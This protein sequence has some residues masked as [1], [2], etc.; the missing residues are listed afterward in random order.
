MSTVCAFYPFVSSITGDCSNLSTGAATIDFSQCTS[1]GFVINWETP[2]VSP[3]PVTINVGTTSYTQT[4]LS[5]G[6]YSAVIYDSCG[7][8]GRTV[9]HISTGTC[10]SNTAVVDT[11][12]GLSNGQLTSQVTYCYGNGAT[13]YLYSTTKGYI[14]SAQTSGQLYTFDTLSADTYYVIGNDGGGCTGSS[15]TCIVKSSTTLSFG[16]YVV[17]TSP[18]NLPANTG[19]GKLYITGLT[20]TAP[21]TY[22]WSNGN[23]HDHITGLTAGA[24]NVTVTDANGCSATTAAIVS[25][26]QQITFGSF[27]IVQSP[28]CF[29]ADGKLQMNIVGGTPPFMYD[30]GHGN[31]YISYSRNYTFTG[32]AADNY[33]FTV[34]DA[35]FCFITQNYQFLGPNSFQIFVNTIPT[36][37]QG[38]SGEID[39]NIIGGLPPFN[40]SLTAAT[41][42]QSFNA[43]GRNY[44]FQNLASG[45]YTLT[46]TDAAG[47]CTY[48]KDFTIISLSTFIVSVSTTGS[49]CGQSNG[50]VKISVSGGSGN[51][52]YTT[53]SGE[54]S[55]TTLSA[56]TF[57]NQ[58]SGTYTATVT[59][60]SSPPCYQTV[61]YTV[62]S[63]SNLNFSLLPT[64]PT[65]G[66]NGSISALISSG[67]PPFTI[68]W[69]S[70]V[71]GQTG[72][73]V[74]S[75]SAGTYSLTVTDASGCTDTQSVTLTGYASKSSYQSFNICNDNF[76]FVGNGIKGLQQ[77]TSEGFKHSFSS[78]TS[79]CTYSS[80]T[81]TAVVSVDGVSSTT[82][83]YTGTTI[84]DVP[85]DEQWSEALQ[86][87]F[88]GYTG[89]TNTIVDLQTNTI[90]LETRCERGVNPL[91]F[92]PIETYLQVNF[93][94]QCVCG[95]PT[96]YI[97][98]E[99]TPILQ[100][101]NGDLLV[102]TLNCTS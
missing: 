27:V 24:Y 64:N 13:F 17:D 84:N 25:T 67:A 79:G 94:A 76:S 11:T 3:N 9:F 82:T 41:T 46:I 60:F 74:S 5:G 22:L 87:L 48:Q 90:T 23:T 31:Q 55:A 77:I 49:T 20:G 100:A 85:T 34:T 40:L 30:D 37:C 83:F 16:I 1:P 91:A 71:N 78:N 28:S 59:D 70:N 47:V 43:P 21:F 33:T 65:I 96:C 52:E 4:G 66:N 18:C 14:T 35:S 54:Y 68:N 73:N 81:F 51:Y 61:S 19:N 44:S 8:T 7:N 72:I 45:T 80:A 56:V 42:N 6:T 92:A 32:L 99:N 75:L 101:Q 98:A 12:C 53:S 89:I 88:S 36:S 62:G 86:T 57:N 26:V 63:S 10:V 102:W 50:Y 95:E 2:G 58:T 97:L 29:N 93:L 38:S 15:E 39:V 69:S